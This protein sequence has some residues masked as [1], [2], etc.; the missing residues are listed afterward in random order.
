M[1]D[2]RVYFV[3]KKE[4][5][6]NKVGVGQVPFRDGEF[7]LTLMLKAF[8]TYT[9]RI[10]DPIVFYTN[11]C[12]NVPEA[13]MKSNLER[14][15]REEMQSALI[16]QIGK[17]GAKKISYDQIPLM[18]EELVVELNR[19]LNEKW[20]EKRGIGIDTLVLTKI[21][22][23]EA[24]VEKI[25]ELQES[26]I[27][28]GQT[29][30]LGARIGAAS[31]SAMGD[32]AN[33]TGGAV[34]GFMGMNMAMGAGGINANELL[35]GAAAQPEAAE[36]WKCECGAE[37][38][39]LFCS[40]CGRKRPQAPIMWKC[41]CGF[42]NKGKFCVRCGKSKPKRYIC[43]KCGY[44]LEF[45]SMPPKFCPQCGDPIDEKDEVTD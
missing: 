26:S 1:N 45:S 5:L 4:I 29:R 37:N 34:T 11:I 32:A 41:E 19:S 25:R 21:V 24:S 38:D 12:A 42:E 6:N 10:K 31:A 3:N 2:Q 28:A 18:T 14:Q 20:R 33:N 22:P 27:Y 16:P 40:E 35:S 43:D 15:L 13:Y 36:R 8:G 39:M 23:D 17:L 9:F 30:M 7:N 44:A